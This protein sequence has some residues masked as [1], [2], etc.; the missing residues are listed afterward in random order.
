MFEH[1]LTDRDLDQADSDAQ[2]FLFGD[3]TD[4]S[5]VQISARSLETESGRVVRIVCTDV[6]GRNHRLVLSEADLR[7]LAAMLESNSSGDFVT[8]LLSSSPND[9]EPCPH[10]GLNSSQ[11]VG[12]PSDE[13]KSPKSWTD[14]ALGS[15][16]IQA[17]SEFDQWL[18]AW[19]EVVTDEP[20]R[21]HQAA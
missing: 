20:N 12:P 4:K 18:S 8:R 16:L 10:A 9:S 13:E 17:P 19:D 1:L 5:I 14:E 6:H 2:A 7:S 21:T 15:A 11:F 3:S